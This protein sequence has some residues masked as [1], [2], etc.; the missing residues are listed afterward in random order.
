M[1]RQDGLAATRRI[2]EIAPDTVIVVV[3]AHRDPQWVVRAA[4]AGASAF[5]PKDELPGRD[6]D[7]LRRVRH[8]SMLVAPS[9]FGGG[10]PRWAAAGERHLVPTLTHRESEVLACL[11]KGLAPKAI[12]RVLGISVHTCRGYVKAL[13]ESS[14][15]VPSSRRSLRPS[16]WV[17][18][19]RL[20]D[21]QTLPGASRV[22]RELVAFVGVGL[23][24][25]I[26]IS[27][28]AVLIIKQV[29][30]HHALREGEQITKQLAELVVAPALDAVLNGNAAQ[31]GDLDRMLDSR[32]RDGSITEINVW[33]V[34]GR[35]VYSDDPS[36]IGRLFPPPAEVVAA[37]LHGDAHSTLETSPETGRSPDGRQVEVYVPL[38]LPGRVLAFEAYF[39][40]RTVEQQS[41]MLTAQIVPTGSARRCGLRSRR[42]AG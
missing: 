5:V 32:M 21:R 2:R 35:V 11:G 10:L 24:V 31:R 1:P 15:C 3:S 23:L 22:R 19:T 7:V 26:I 13:L 36:V 30:E 9:A 38:R 14:E 25:L 20:M 29:A 8:G 27:I 28:G 39:N 16:S 34:E 17:S 4:Q 41:A 42:C 18:S 12:A 6:V 33:T 40:Y 37:V